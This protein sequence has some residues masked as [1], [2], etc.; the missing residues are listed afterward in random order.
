MA[1]EIARDPRL[2]QLGCV[3]S[4]NAMLAG[5]LPK[6]GRC[7][8]KKAQVYRTAMA[9]FRSCLASMNQPGRDLL[10][11]VLLAK[12]LRIVKT[13]SRGVKVQVTF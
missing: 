5:S 1:R 13:N 12:K 7:R 8:N 2:A 11:R 3:S 4:F 9:T 6:C 10:K